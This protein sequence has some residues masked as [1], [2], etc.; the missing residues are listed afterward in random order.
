[1]I[2]KIFIFLIASVLISLTISV[3]E[4]FSNNLSIANVSLE[5]RNPSSNSVTVEFDISWDNSWQTKINHDAVWV[6][7][8]LYDPAV[9]PTDKKLC[10]MKESG[11]NPTGTLIDPDS[12]LEIVIP[13]DKM[14]AFIRLDSYG[15]KNTAEVSDVELTIDYASCGLDDSDS[16]SVSVLGIEMVYVPEGSFYVGDNDTST[17]SL[18]QGSADPD[19]WFISSESAVSVTNPASDGYRYVSAGNSGEN[20]TGSS[21]TIPAT[22]PKGYGA[23]YAMKYEINEE[24]WV[25]FVNS[26]PS[27]AA[28]ANRDITNASHKNS[29]SVINRNT[30]SCSGSSVTCSTQRPAR[31]VSYLTWMDLAAFL[32]W[33][34]LRPMTELEYEKMSRGPVF[35]IE[36]EYAWGAT[37]IISATAVSSGDE[38]GTELSTN[39]GANAH[40]GTVTLTGGDSVNGSG[41]DQGPLRIG[42]FATSSSDRVSSGAGYYG[43]LDLSGNL[44]ER[45]VTIGNDTGRSFTESHGDG[46]LSTDS[47]YEGNATNADWPGVNALS[48][49]GVTSAEGSGFKGGAWN[50][51]SSSLRISDRSDAANASAIAAGNAGGRGVRSYDSN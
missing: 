14:G 28:R 35:P 27:A 32:D 1:K 12:G 46:V 25:A 13:Q 22:Y 20:S 45:V 7:V 11:T 38:N 16:A 51:T 31:A 29:D 43:V 39:S 18:D 47:G 9:V 34:A 42:I 44:S 10:Q 49:R 2:K 6:T 3:T 30:I 48:S 19:P 36:G 24:Q 26:L 4:S 17:A 5:E 37:N 33:A 50:S 40:Y 15:K 41:Y 21:F 8:R 23:F